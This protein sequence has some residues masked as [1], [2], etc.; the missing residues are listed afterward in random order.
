MK[1]NQ[2]LGTRETYELAL[3]MGSDMSLSR[4]AGIL[5][6]LTDA[7]VAV[8]LMNLGRLFIASQGYGQPGKAHLQ[9]VDDMAE[10]VDRIY[11]ATQAAAY[12]TTP[13]QEITDE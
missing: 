8:A 7:Q 3:K 12:A 9:E 4:T 13:A 2:R 1:E 10:R 5:A 11:E 6:G